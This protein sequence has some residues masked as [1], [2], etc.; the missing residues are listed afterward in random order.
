V[1]AVLNLL[2]PPLALRRQTLILLRSL[3]LELALQL[4]PVV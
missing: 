1:N 4:A 3:E 2:P